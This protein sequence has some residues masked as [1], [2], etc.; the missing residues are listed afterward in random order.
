VAKLGRRPVLDDTKKREILAILSV[1]CSRRAAAAYV[2]CAVKTI[3]NEMRRD[4]NFTAEIERRETSV[5]IGYIRNIQNAAKSEKNWRAAAWFLERRFPEEFGPKKSESLR[6]SQI[7][8]LLFGLAG[9]IGAE[10]PV[11]A[12]RKQI[13][14][15]LQ[16]M[17]QKLFNDNSLLHKASEEE[18]NDDGEA[19]TPAND[20]NTVD[21]PGGDETDEQA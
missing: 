11:A 14:K 20:L 18:A 2:G 4:E 5:E 13:L 1:G 6:H 16:R 17:M 10:V 7:E 19:A 12:F 3:A 15:R 8:D 9:I 21:A